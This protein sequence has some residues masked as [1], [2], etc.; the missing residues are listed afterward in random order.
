VP[1]VLSPFDKKL[2]PKFQVG[3]CKNP[4]H[5]TRTTEYSIC[6]PK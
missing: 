6:F 3:Q 1:P 4:K 2:Q 5:K